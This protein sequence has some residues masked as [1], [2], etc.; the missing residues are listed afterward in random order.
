MSLA[1]LLPPGLEAAATTLALIVVTLLFLYFLRRTTWRGLPTAT[2]DRA[3]VPVHSEYFSALEQVRRKN[4]LPA[5]LTLLERVSRLDF[6]R[7]TYEEAAMAHY[8]VWRYDALK[9]KK[10]LSERDFLELLSLSRPILGLIGVEGYEH[11]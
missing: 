8:L 7:L 1:P 6:S 2:A 3:A 9:N 11:S 4:L 5:A 10:K